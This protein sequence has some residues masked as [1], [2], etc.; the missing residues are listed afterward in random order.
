MSLFREFIKGVGSRQ[1]L[2]M[3]GLGLCQAL[4]VTVSLEGALW[5]SLAMTCLLVAVNGIVSL[6]RRLMTPGTALLLAV[7]VSTTLATALELLLQGYRPAAVPLLG[8]YLPLAAV[9]SLVVVRA[10]EYAA[11]RGAAASLADGLGMGL[12]FTVALVA[13]AALREIVG[14]NRLL[15]YPV[16]PGFE[17]VAVIVS[18]PGAFIVLGLV[19][20]AARAILTRR[21]EE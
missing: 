18:A 5:M 8:V 10:G 9:S 16:I 11:E 17:P 15:G 7:I 19:M 2:L 6:T 13:I 1:P 14:A 12:G 21:G 3:L 20:W 4:A